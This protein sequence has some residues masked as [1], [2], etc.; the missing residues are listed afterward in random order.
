MKEELQNQGYKCSVGNAV[1]PLADINHHVIYASCVPTNGSY[2]ETF[3]ITH[4]DTYN[5]VE[6]LKH[7]LKK[8][9]MGICMSKETM[10]KL[11]V[12]LS[13]PAPD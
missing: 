6:F 10:E 11:S 2:N 7:Q 3:M 12:L 5:K 13:H 9:K 8:A 1:D 4:I